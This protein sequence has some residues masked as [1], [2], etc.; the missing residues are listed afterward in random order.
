MSLTKVTYAMIDG[1][2]YNAL[3]FGADPTGS[4][5]CTAAYNAA[6]AKITASGEPGMLVFPTGTY[7]FDD[8]ITIDVSLM[9][10]QGINSRFD[11]TNLD[12]SKKAITIT[13]SVGNIYDQIKDVLTGVVVE[14]PGTSGTSIGIYFDAPSEP[15]PAHS[16]LRNVAVT[17][18][19]YGISY[20]ANAYILTFD[21]CN[22]YANNRGVQTFVGAGSNSGERITFINSSI[23]NNEVYGVRVEDSNASVHLIGCSLDYNQQALFINRGALQLTSCFLEFTDPI[24]GQDPRFLFADGLGGNTVGV[25]FSDCVFKIGAVAAPASTP[26][27]DVTSTVN[28]SHS[29]CYFFLNSN[30]TEIFKMR[31]GSFYNEV[32]AKAQYVGGSF[33]TLDAGCIYAIN[34]SGQNSVG[35]KTNQQISTETPLYN[36]Y[37]VVSITDIFTS[38]FATGNVATSNITVT[39]GIYTLYVHTYSGLNSTAIGEYLITRKGTGTAVTTVVANASVSV[40]VNGSYF[41]EV[42]NT[43]GGNRTL[44]C[45]IV[46]QAIVNIV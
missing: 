38:T 37:N 15:G 45:T 27:F 33:R 32:N 20:G 26:V 16:A 31:T 3:D 13:G 43:S 22:I 46:K 11:F 39:E 8:S 4:N 29:N 19:N 6:V 34:S 10:V 28:L 40:A 17:N 12:T 2:P 36:V 24:G 23:F 18:F 30:R 21:H 1:A 7:R 35:I 42:T 44:D 5:D 9:S 25:M 14:G 41:I